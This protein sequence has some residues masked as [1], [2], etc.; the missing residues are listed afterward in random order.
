MPRVRRTRLEYKESGLTFRVVKAKRV[1][2]VAQAYRRLKKDEKE[3]SIPEKGFSP[4]PNFR[5]AGT[6]QCATREISQIDKRLQEKPY[7]VVVTNTVP[8]WSVSEDPESYAL[9]VV[10]EDLSEVEVK[11]YTQIQAQLEERV[12]ARARA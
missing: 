10:I 4:S 3:D 11:L 7:F 1:E 6:V 5:S 12:R 9:V 2:E 8:D